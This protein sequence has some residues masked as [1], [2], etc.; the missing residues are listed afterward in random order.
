[1]APLLYVYIHADVQVH[2]EGV[3]IVLHAS[4]WHSYVQQ[5]TVG[6]LGPHYLVRHSCHWK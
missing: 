3:H 1:M 5:P 4:L 6:E 2:Y